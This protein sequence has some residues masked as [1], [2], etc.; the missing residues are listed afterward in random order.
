M[1][2][3]TQKLKIQDL[4]ADNQQVRVLMTYLGS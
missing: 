4:E 1:Q 3:E 2:L